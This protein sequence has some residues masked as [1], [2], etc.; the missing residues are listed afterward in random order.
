MNKR[1]LVKRAEKEADVLTEKKDLI[2]R[3]MD[4]VS[5][6]AKKSGMT[7]KSYQIEIVGQDWHLR[8]ET[9]WPG[10]VWNVH[11]CL[12]N[13]HMFE[14]EVCGDEISIIFSYDRP[15]TGQIGQWIKLIFAERKGMLSL[16]DVCTV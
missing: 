11:Y 5:D 14:V 15:E 6:I 10:C 13:C 7:K 2:V 3:V 8:D 4:C 16:R 9:D 12:K 1:F